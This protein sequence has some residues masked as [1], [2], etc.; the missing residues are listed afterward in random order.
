[1]Y[2]TI[3]QLKTIIQQYLSFRELQGLTTMQKRMSLK[4]LVTARIEL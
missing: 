4:N 3:S 2:T 1:M